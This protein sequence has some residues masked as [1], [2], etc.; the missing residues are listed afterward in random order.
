MNKIS[1]LL[2]ITI[3]MSACKSNQPPLETVDFVDLEKYSGTWFEIASFPQ[4]FQK[5]CFCTSATYTPKDGYIEVYNQCNKDSLDGKTSS[6]TGKAFVQNPGKNTKLKVQF[7][8]PFKG[9]YWIIGLGKQY[10]YALVGTQSREYLWILSRE[11]T[12][13][14]DT[15]QIILNELTEKGFDVTMLEKTVQDCSDK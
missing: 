7:F 12:M 3:L 15:Y 11:R 10:E 9:D 14:E 8:W 6:V 4:R 13:D 1:R 5:G 2:L